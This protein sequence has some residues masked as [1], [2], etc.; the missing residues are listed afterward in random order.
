MVVKRVED[1]GEGWEKAEGEE[2]VPVRAIFGNVF[3]NVVLAFC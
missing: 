3:L 1:G 2:K